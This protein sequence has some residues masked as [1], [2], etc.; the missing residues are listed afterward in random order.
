VSSAR[1]VL[2]PDRQPWA[3]LTRDETARLLGPTGVRWWFTGGHALELH[4]GRSWR[5]HDDV[6]VGILRSDVA[7]FSQALADHDVRLAAAGRLRALPARPLR[8][9]LHENN[10]WVRARGSGPWCLDVTISEG[11][12]EAWAY[13][14]QPSRRVPWPDAV[15]VDPEGLPYLAPELQLL[16][17]SVSVRAKDGVDAAVVIPALKPHRRDRLATWL[18]PDH[19]WRGFLR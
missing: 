13:R 12:D 10:L 4:L 7:A 1:E 6:D 16:H 11:D 9:A 15:L 14:R 18:D 2:P 5:A 3:P 19:P 8:T 17:K